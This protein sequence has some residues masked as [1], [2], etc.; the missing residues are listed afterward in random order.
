MLPLCSIGVGHSFPS[1]GHVYIIH[2]IALSV[3]QF[4]CYSPL[5]SH[6]KNVSHTL[7]DT[8]Y[9]PHKC[10]RATYLMW[11]KSLGSVICMEGGKL[12]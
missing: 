3:N 2:A 10:T 9:I 1:I 4:S 5:H 12:A 6:A 8:C 11:L 7:W